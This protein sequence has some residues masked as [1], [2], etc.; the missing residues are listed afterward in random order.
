MQ[1][2]VGYRVKCP[3]TVIDGG[4]AFFVNGEGRHKMLD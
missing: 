1:I 2:N 3:A 4:Q